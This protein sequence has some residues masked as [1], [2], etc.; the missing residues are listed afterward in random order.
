M[1]EV[2]TVRTALTRARVTSATVEAT[3]VVVMAAEVVVVATAAVAVM[4][5][6]VEAVETADME[7]A[8]VETRTAIL[9]KRLLLT[10]IMGLLAITTIIVKLTRRTK[11]A[12]LA[13]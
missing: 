10:W 11:E 5:V 4:V 8:V 2:L 9:M 13:R 12:N 3:V 1:H 7:M 6:V